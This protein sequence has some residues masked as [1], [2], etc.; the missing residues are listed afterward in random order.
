MLYIYFNILW[1]YVTLCNMG[2]HRYRIVFGKVTHTH[3]IMNCLKVVVYNRKMYQEI[4]EVK[5]VCSCAD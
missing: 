3:N 2:S 5:E 1:L 4:T